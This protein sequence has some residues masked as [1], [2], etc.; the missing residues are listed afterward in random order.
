MILSNCVSQSNSLDSS[1]MNI[2]DL[3]NLSNINTNMFLFKVLSFNSKC[4]IHK[5]I[6]SSVF[7]FLKFDFIANSIQNFRVFWKLLEKNEFKNYNEK[8]RM[9]NMTLYL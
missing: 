1:T 6:V 3:Y 7:H 2:N 4:I 9:R 5:I 8:N